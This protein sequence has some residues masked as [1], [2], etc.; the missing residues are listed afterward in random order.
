MAKTKKQ[1]REFVE[2][3]SNW[4]TVEKTMLHRTL[5]LD[6]KGHRWMKFDAW[7]VRESFRW[8]IE[9]GAPEEFYE[10]QEI[11]VYEFNSEKDAITERTTIPRIADKVWELSRR[12]NHAEKKDQIT[13]P[14]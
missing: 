2:D 14:E 9:H 1:A 8:E 3:N 6:Y 7:H 10:W 4:Q 12:N 5:F 11:G 13:D